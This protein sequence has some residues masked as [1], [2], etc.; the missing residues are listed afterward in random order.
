[1]S[2]QLR[3]RID[4]WFLSRRPPSDRLQLM[5]NNVYIVPTRAGWMLAATVLVLLV[6]SI[7]YQL[8]LGYLLTFLL[9][10]SVAAGMYVSHATLRGLSLHLLPPEPQFAGAA[11]ILRVVLDNDRRS[12]RWGIGVAVRHASG[13]RQW[14]WC[15]VPA[16]GSATVE[17]AFQPE[18]RGLH[19]VPPLV[20]E[21]RFPL[22]TFRVW[23]VWRPA[24]QVLVY[25]APEAHPP[26]LPLG[27]PR[28]DAQAGASARSPSQS[29]EFDGVRAYRRGD[30]LKLVAWKKVA[31]A[32]AAGTDELYSRDAQQ[33]QQSQ[34]WLDAQQAGLPAHEAR[35]SRLTAWVL[36][37]DRLGTDYGLRIAGREIEP[38]QGEAHKRQCLE[39]LATC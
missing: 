24:A 27:E 23:T 17:V 37:A 32:L 39:L 6:A 19:S 1:M 36:M 28:T 11:A 31:R 9:A 22:G 2:A 14:A 12:P 33:A 21:T 8:N 16:L 15:D 3:Q 18:R 10:G 29:G 30:P 13:A 35:L 5:Q 34:L 20:V 4:G 38:G 25:P 26:A 7:N